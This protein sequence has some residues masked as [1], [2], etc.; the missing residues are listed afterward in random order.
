MLEPKIQ[1]RDLDLFYGQNQALKGINK[2]PIR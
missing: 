2:H 1:V